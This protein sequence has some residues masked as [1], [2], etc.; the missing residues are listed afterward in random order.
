ME[1]YKF[2]LDIAIILAMTKSFSLVSKKFNMAASRWSID[3]G[4]HF[5]T[6]G[7]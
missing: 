4:N 7:P 1:E 5:R 3:R 2:L 6:S